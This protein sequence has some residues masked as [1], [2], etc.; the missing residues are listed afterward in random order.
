MKWKLIETKKIKPLE[1]VF[2][3]HLTNLSKMILNSGIMKF[4]L[5]IDDKYHIVLDGSHRYVFLKDVGYKF[6]PVIEVD[7]GDPH[8]RVGT[9]RMHRHIINGPVGISKEE[10]IRRGLTGDLFPPRTTR[11]FIPFLRPEINMP[12]EKLG[13]IKGEDMSKLIAK[14]DVREEINHNK[15]YI[16]EIEEEENEL[17]CYLEECIRIK[18]YLKDQIKEMKNER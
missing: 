14:V 5:I 18:K 10:V 15:K 17:T 4:P 9:H 2:P 6:T 8:V 16:K 13:R 3:N 12:L 1:Y 7:Y 11:H